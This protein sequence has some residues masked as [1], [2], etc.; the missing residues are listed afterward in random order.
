MLGGG[1]SGAKH[2]PGRTSVVP[3]GHG[4]PGFTWTP[5]LPPRPP[6]RPWAP[7]AGAPGGSR[8]SGR[9]PSTRPQPEYRPFRH[10]K[11]GHD[12]TPLTMTSLETRGFS[13]P[14]HACQA[15][16]TSAAP[17]TH[18]RVRSH[19]LTGDTDWS[20]HDVTP[21]VRQPCAPRSSRRVPGHRHRLCGRGA[22]GSRATPDA[23]VEAGRSAFAAGLLSRSLRLADASAPAEVGMDTAQTRRGGR[24]SPSRTR[25][26]RTK[27]LAVDLATTFGAPSRSTRRSARQGARRRQR[28]R[29]PPRLRRR[30]MGRHR[31][32]SDMTFSVTKTFLSTVVG[33]AWQ[34]RPDPR[35]APIA[36]RDY[37]PP[38]VDL[39]ESEHNATITWEHL[40]RQT[41]D[42]QGTLWG[43]P[44][45]A[46]RP[47]G[48]DARPSGRTASCHEPGTLYKYNDM[49][50]NVLALADAARVAAPAARGAARGGHG[51]DRRVDHLALV[52]LRQLVGRDRR[53]AHA[54][55]AGRRPLRRRHV[56]QRLGH[57]ALRLSVPAQRQV[58]RTARSSRRSGSRWRARP[59]PANA[60]TTAS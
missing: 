60:E 51:S 54:V 5:P 30:R 46:D 11:R 35:R 4:S 24:S 41:S 47:E 7:A 25:T 50:V 44:D 28:P 19:S 33:L 37:M 14:R 48:A 2:R 39:F 9:D 58:E 49:R 13:L 10:A 22:A 29:H 42:W 8:A 32:A 21:P 26:P 34:T 38:G 55:G 43:K 56:H 40:L 52:R 6:C 18:S 17:V 59:G 57:G 53:Q 45:W 27:D 36:S 31:R 16:V 15:G 23:D 3:G 20:P 12:A 1:N